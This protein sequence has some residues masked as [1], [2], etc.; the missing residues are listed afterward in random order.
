MTATPIRPWPL[1]VLLALALL[2]AGPSGL[3]AAGPA[4]PPT[5]QLP[6]D[7]VFRLDAELTDQDGRAFRLAELRGKPVLVAMFYTSCKYICPLIVD[8]MRGIDHALDASERSGLRVLLVSMD[9]ARD[10]PQALRA[11]VDQ[12][13]LDTGRW[14]LAR[15]DAAQV[16]RVAAVLGARYRALADGEFNHT[17]SIVLLDRD[18]RPVATTAASG[19]AADPAFVAAVRAALAPR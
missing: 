12:R 7:S 19:P 15:T 16:R 2:A 3:L 10:T 17:S 14:T 18:G 9:P 4:D 11:V 13:R 1:A 8:S 5:A 6:G